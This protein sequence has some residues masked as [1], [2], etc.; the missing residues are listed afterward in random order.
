V[1]ADAV[2]IE[3]NMSHA[4]MVPVLDS[5]VQEA[6]GRYVVDD[7]GFTMPGDWVLSVE[8]TLPDGR[9]ARTEVPANVVGSMGGGG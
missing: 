9:T 5:A 6:P 7:F 8:A 3:G 4:G 2:R 1:E